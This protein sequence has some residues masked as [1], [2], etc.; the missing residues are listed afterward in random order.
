MK[1]Q[2]HQAAAWLEEGRLDDAVASL[3]AVL[4]QYPRQPDARLM[5][6]IAQSR[7]GDSEGAAK[8]LREL[9]D[10]HP[11][12]VAAWYNLGVV[13]RE[14]RKPAE[15]FEAFASAVAKEPNHYAALV[16]AG[17]AAGALEDWGRAVEYWE[18]ATA[19]KPDDSNTAINLG[20]ALTHCS[21]YD[22]ARAKFESVLRVSPR[23]VAALNGMGM[24]WR[25]AGHPNRAIDC[26]DRALSFDPNHAGVL[27]NRGKALTRANRFA[28]A[29]SDFEKALAVAPDSADAAMGLSVVEA[30]LTNRVSATKAARRALAMLP[31][32]P[33]ALFNLAALL[34]KETAAAALTEADGLLQRALAARDGMADAWHCRAQ[35]L[36]KL[37]RTAQA[38][39]ASERAMR[40]SPD[41][42]KF[43]VTHALLQ[44]TD[45]H[46]ADAVKTL[47]EQARR[48]PHVA[49]VH[50]QLGIASLRMDL[51][52]AA[53][54][55]LHRAYRLGED[56]QRTIAYLGLATAQLGNLDEARRWLGLPTVIQE[57]TLGLPDGFETLGEFNRALASAIR[58]HS[59]LRWEP[60]GLAAVNGA[61]TDDLLADRNPA[62]T[63]FELA[64]RRQIDRFVAGLAPDPDDP[65]TRV[66]P[67]AYDLN[68]W[69]TLVEAPGHI[70]T[71][72]HEE[73]WLSGAYYVELPESMDAPDNGSAGWIEFGRPHAN[74][75]FDAEELIELRQPHT[76]QLLLFPSYLFHR[77]LPHRVG[78]RISVSFDLVPRTE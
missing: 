77:T 71:H 69:A 15:A 73:S 36:G 74:D 31:D 26:Y 78:Q 51:R 42:P 38:L 35:V 50:R 8:A 12:F 10:E 7:A 4:E 58:S 48:H 24:T 72:I 70:A 75:P 65:F 47:Q 56:D 46:L 18:R 2:L 49:E 6:G 45:G 21:R 37:G 28:E 5:R 43:A 55:A 59:A 20:V 16:N 61:L 27:V 67:N 62:T 60:I 57:T 32:N 25:A 9:V 3:D 22:D 66:I 11:Q 29:R 17:A 63:G 44:E 52:E 54:E 39:E 33:D 34:S 40:E 76:G 64:L 14:S 19:L 13:L 41:K 68:I 23:N 53:K 30:K 1:E